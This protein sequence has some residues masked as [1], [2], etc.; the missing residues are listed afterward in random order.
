M[1]NLEHLSNTFAVKSVSAALTAFPQRVPILMTTDRRKAQL[2]IEYTEILEYLI[3]IESVMCQIVVL[4]RTLSHAEM[5]QYS[6]EA[7]GQVVAPGNGRGKSGLHRAACRLTAGGPARGY[8][9]CHR[10]YTASKSHKTEIGV[11]VKWCG[12]SAPHPEQ[13]GW[14]GKPHAEQDQIGEEGR[15]VPPDSR[16]G[17]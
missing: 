11:R 7:A 6:S 5:R 13:S 14:Q 16:V 12:K 2:R 15:P 1:R 3:Q 9:K 8:G 4:R 10:K 17:R